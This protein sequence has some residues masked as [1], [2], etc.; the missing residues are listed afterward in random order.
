MLLSTDV[1]VI[2]LWDHASPIKTN[3]FHDW[4]GLSGHRFFQ[5]GVLDPNCSK[6]PANL[7]AV[8]GQAKGEV[9]S[10]SSTSCLSKRTETAN[11]TDYNSDDYDCREGPT[12]Q[13]LRGYWGHSTNNGDNPSVQSTPAHSVY[14]PPC[15]NFPANGYLYINTCCGQWISFVPCSGILYNNSTAIIKGILLPLGPSGDIDQSN[16]GGHRRTRQTRT[17]AVG[18]GEEL[19]GVDHKYDDQKS[20]RK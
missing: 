12:N 11:S 19:R 8:K 9:I 18:T 15:A 6:P 2:R 5:N 7:G 3:H 20:R 14:A 10:K 17:R 16:V 1:K 13:L 4:L